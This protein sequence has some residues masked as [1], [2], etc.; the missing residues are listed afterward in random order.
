MRDFYAIKDNKRN[1]PAKAQNLKCFS[2]LKD[3]SKN[4]R[5]LGYED[6]YDDLV[7]FFLGI[8]TLM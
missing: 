8:L 5:M 6:A 1:P 4:A 3:C 7:V 2:A